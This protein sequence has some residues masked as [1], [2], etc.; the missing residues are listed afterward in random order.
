MICAFTGSAFAQENYV[1]PVPV[2][3]GAMGF[4]TTVDGGHAELAPAFVPVMLIPLGDRWL[5]E[6][7]AEFTGD[8]QRRNGSFYGGGGTS[9][10]TS[11]IVNFTI[12]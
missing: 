4:I 6:S 3:S 9:D 1:K 11:N 8:F 5:I 10:E 12:N 7:R 2:F